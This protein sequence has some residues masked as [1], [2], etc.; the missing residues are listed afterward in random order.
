MLSHGNLLS[1]M[2]ASMQMFPPP[3]REYVMLNFL[4]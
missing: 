3:G 2:Y 4:P 1:S